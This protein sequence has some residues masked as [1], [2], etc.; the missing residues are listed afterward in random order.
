V[1]LERMDFSLARLYDVL[2]GTNEKKSKVKKAQLNIQRETTWI[3]RIMRLS[4]KL[5]IG[6][7]RRKRKSFHGSE[8][9]AYLLI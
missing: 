6:M 8:T 2:L 1:K 4:E 5:Q 7:R 9:F 3:I